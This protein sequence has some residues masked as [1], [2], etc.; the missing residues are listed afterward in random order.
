M[1]AV[2]ACLLADRDQDVTAPLYTFDLP[3]Q[4]SQLRRIDL[5]IRRV[6][7][8]ERRFDTF[9]IRSRVVITRG[10]EGIKHIVSIGARD[11][12]SHLIVE[13]TVGRVS[14]RRLLVPLQRA[15]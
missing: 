8:Y 12:P 5:I 6:D 14:G 3:F 13:K 2:A 1:G 4:N 15:T 10:I 7:C 9:E 11:L